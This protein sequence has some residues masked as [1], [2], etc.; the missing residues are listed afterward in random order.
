V[1]LGARF[2]SAGSDAD[3]LRT[4]ARQRVAALRAGPDG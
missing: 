1:A 4:A 3:L 2:V